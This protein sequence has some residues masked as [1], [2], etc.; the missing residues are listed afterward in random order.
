MPR[1][2]VGVTHFLAAPM[3]L[4]I[5]V[6]LTCLAVLCGATAA[7]AVTPVARD[8]SAAAPVSA[9]GADVR[10]GPR[11]VPGPMRM[12]QGAPVR[13]LRLAPPGAAEAETMAARNRRAFAPTRA[14]HGQ[15]LA[16]GYPR[17][18]DAAI[19][20]RDLAWA[21]AAAGARIA[22][23]ELTSP[24][25]RA[26]RVALALE[27][28]RD[29]ITVRVASAGADE[30]VAVLA[31]GEIA[32]AMHRDGA[33]WS[34][35]LEGDT[36]VVEIEA[37]AGVDVA[38]ARLDIPRLAHLVVG[39]ADLRAP[40]AAV[41]RASGIGAAAACN[42]DA[43]CA[44]GSDAALQTLA[45]S[46]A[47]I[48]FV[49]QDGFSYLCSGTLLNDTARTN[50]PYLFT[51]DHCIDSMAA[52]RSIVSFWLFTATS[53][54]GKDTPPFVQLA[55]GGTLLGRS[56]DNDWSLVRLDAMPPAGTRLASW[57]A[58]PIA[59]GTAVVALHH[60]RGDL[61]K[62]N[63]GVVTGALRVQD[64][65]V[66]GAFTQVTW[67]SGITEGGSSGG[68]LATADG[69]IYEVRGGLYGGLSSC[70]RPADPDYFSRLET[71]L[72]LMRQYL[73][74]AAANLGGTTVAVEFH[75]AALD[76][77]FLSTEPS[78]IDN[79]DSGRTTGWERTGLRF[80]AYPTKV[81]GAQP[82]CRLY[83]VPGHGDAHFYSANPAEC[84]AALAAAPGE[85]IQEN[86]AAFYLPLPDATSGECPAGTV[87]VYRY[88]NRVT[89]SHRYTIERV[90][91]LRMR[92]SPEW[93]AEGY[94][95]GPFFPAMCAVQPY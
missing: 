95:R 89:A 84:A 28:A 85:W 23:V 75:N 55:G 1:R 91:S 49:A 61:L 76:R 44:I 46:V 21:N 8:A 50:T 22:R 25:A 52:A 45:S 47:R 72:P 66:D 67:T 94:G 27:G 36:A 17:G 83:R 38:T 10:P 12:P 4:S 70:S 13:H 54:G 14:W 65:L 33:L 30:A 34:P 5:L 60:P 56:Q 31:A 48:V 79:L 9:P 40:E 7:Q 68:L 63:H 92:T 2:H 41:M 39:G 82:V 43:A 69:G 86:A 88:F 19:P 15:P 53:C 24:G 18:V 78:E 42:V 6:P 80:L 11:P 64:E 81:E 93:I 87:P 35:V 37:R 74:P 77:Y 73:T 71:M 59:P 26:L 29:G 57:R 20:L 16:I 51:A 3:R 62:A 90:T 58:E 32:Q